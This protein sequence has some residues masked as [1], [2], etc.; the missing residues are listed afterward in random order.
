MFRLFLIIALAF[1]SGTA[2]ASAHESDPSKAVILA[3]HRI[4]EPQYIDSNL[5]FEQFAA[6]VR[7]IKASN[8]N[9]LPL[10]HITTAIH[11]NASLPT[12]TIAITFD[13]S[14]RS[15]IKDAIPLLIKEDLP[16]TIFI[17][18]DSTHIKNHLSWR[19]IKRLKKYHGA[20]F[21]I[22][23]SS[24]HISDLPIA[25]AT[26]LI[27]TSRI[28]FKKHTKREAQFFAY[29]FG[30]IS[31]SLKQAA[32]KQ[33][34]IA[35][36]GLHSGPAHNQS[37][38]T[39]LPRFTMTNQYADLERFRMLTNT[40]PLPY[41]EAEPQNWKLSSPIKQIG[42]TIAEDIKTQNMSCHISGQT[43]PEI[44][45]LGKRVEI[46]TS[47]PISQR[48]RVNCTLPNHNGDNKQWRWLGMLFH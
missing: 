31:N 22:Y 38:I 26:R 17:A 32:K 43:K 23:P 9:V 3:Y 47:E 4:D 2:I 33:G 20:S 39:A 12:K 1:T 18:T 37:D 10:E 41:K 11:R 13:A 36:F 8:Y 15:I 42:F 28:A 30:E 27:N 24:Q 29:P 40:A 5:S 21:G 16:F 46:I 25:E 45:I 14:H 6:H 19:D 44:E 35:A 7:E 34:F 48:T